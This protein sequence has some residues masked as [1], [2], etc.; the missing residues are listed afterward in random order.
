[1]TN[2]KAP[3]SMRVVL[4]WSSLGLNLDLHSVQYS[5][6]SKTV[7]H[8]YI[9]YNAGC[10]YS[11]QNFKIKNNAVRTEYNNINLSL[12]TGHYNELRSKDRCDVFQSE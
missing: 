6:T 9:T 7:R 11:E 10:T 2:F 4:S 8:C 1:M 3:D 12:N 5:K